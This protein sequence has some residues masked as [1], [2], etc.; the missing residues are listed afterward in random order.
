MTDLSK[1]TDHELAIL[2]MGHELELSAIDDCPDLTHDEDGTPL[3][4]REE[5]ELE[6]ARFITELARRKGQLH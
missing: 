3:P 4:T 1:Y 5:L 2:I 6:V